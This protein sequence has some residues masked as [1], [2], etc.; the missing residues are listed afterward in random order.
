MKTR[1]S[2]VGLL[3]F[4]LGFLVWLSIPA[5]KVSAQNS[6][7]TC[8][9]QCNDNYNRCHDTAVDALTVCLAAAST[10]AAREVCTEKYEAAQARCKTAHDVCI[11]HC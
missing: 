1:L 8:V 6:Q 10:P 3:V 2:L 4:F 11:D 5:T 7:A 9:E